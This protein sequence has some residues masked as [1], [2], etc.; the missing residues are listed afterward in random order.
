MSL[1][2]A[3]S[4]TAFKQFVNSRSLSIQWVED[5]GNYYLTAVDN[6]FSLNCVLNQTTDTSDISDFTTNFQPNGN[7]PLKTNVVQQLGAD[8]VSICPFGT[9]FNAPAN[10]TTTFD[11]KFTNTVYL[12]GGIM[13][14]SPGNVGDTI[15]V[16]VVDKD[17]ITGAG[18][19]TVLAT[20]VNGWYVIPEDMNAVEDVSLSQPMVSG[21]Y[22]RFIYTNSSAITNSNVIIN[23]LA[24]NGTI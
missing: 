13:Y 10:Q 17:N 15:T 7:Q 2:I 4:W 14:A 22:V 16:Q 9:M 5:Y 11:L 18:A 3:V 21:L 1:S 20:Y 23:L 24:Y 12:K 19:G 6:F 8:S